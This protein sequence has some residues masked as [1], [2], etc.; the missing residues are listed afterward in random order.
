M[1]AV[2]V[3]ALGRRAI[4]ALM[5]SGRQGRLSLVETAHGRRRVE[6]RA[7]RPRPLPARS[8]AP[9]RLPA[10]GAAAPR[11]AFP[12]AAA[13]AARCQA[14][15]RGTPVQTA[16]E[17]PTAT[18]QGAIGVYHAA[19]RGASHTLAHKATPRDCKT[20]RPSQGL[21]FRVDK[22]YTKN[23]T[24]IEGRPGGCR[25]FPLDAGFWNC[26]LHA[27]CRCTGSRRPHKRANDT[28]GRL[29]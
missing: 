17:G 9:A 2:R 20:R 10:G 6:A 24:R 29:L 25:N 19:F 16:G 27:C 5:V 22:S 12:L 3:L 23:E 15:S 14:S 7:V 26:I 8:P 28:T 21:L 1:I 18:F 11:P 4:L 13:A